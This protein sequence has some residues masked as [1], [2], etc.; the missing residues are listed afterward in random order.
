MKK[1]RKIILLDFIYILISIVFFWEKSFPLVGIGI[2][3]LGIVLLKY[4]NQKPN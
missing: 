1:F 4:Y 3:V 2:I